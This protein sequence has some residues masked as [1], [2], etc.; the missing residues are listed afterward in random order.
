MLEFIQSF[1]DNFSFMKK[2][3][4]SRFLEQLHGI[5]CFSI[6]PDLIKKIKKKIGRRKDQS[7]CV[8][9]STSAHHRRDPSGKEVR[10]NCVFSLPVFQ[11]CQLSVHTSPCL[12]INGY[13]HLSLEVTP[14]RAGDA[15]SG[16]LR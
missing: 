12:S 10:F 5:A 13:K 8:Q 3:S 4:D 15:T 16:L 6:T 11:I 1:L 14:A 2:R 7:R 9:S